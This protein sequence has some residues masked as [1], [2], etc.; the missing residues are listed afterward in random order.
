[1]LDRSQIIAQAVAGHGG[2]ITIDAGTFLPSAD[3]L[4]SASSQLGIS[5]TIDVIGPRVDLNGSLVV[6]AGDLRAAAAISRDN[7]VEHG[8]R[9]RSSLADVGR[10]G[11]TQDPDA[12]LPAFYIA[13]REFREAAAAPPALPPG[14]QLALSPVSGCNLRGG[15]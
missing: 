14:P 1:V 9:P 3:S 2:N 8:S 15:F 4:V 7:C 5:G 11:I 12:L 6:L 13:G 10:G